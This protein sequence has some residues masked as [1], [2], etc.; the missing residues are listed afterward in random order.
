MISVRLAPADGKPATP[1]QPGQFLTVRLHP[2]PEA[3]PLLRTYSL[4][5]A[6]ER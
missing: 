2:D 1:A 4:S 5:G 3:A 6:P